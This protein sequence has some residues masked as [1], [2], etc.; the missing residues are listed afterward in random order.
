MDDP[1]EIRVSLEEAEARLEE[2]VEASLAG[3]DVMIYD[4]R[5]PRARFMPLDQT[6]P[7]E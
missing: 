7:A 4:N 5:G 3:A 1:I 6:E 2:L